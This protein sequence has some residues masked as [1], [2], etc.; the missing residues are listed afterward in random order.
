MNDLLGT[1][2][3]SNGTLVPSGKVRVEQVRFGG[4][5]AYNAGSVIPYIGLNYIYDLKKP[6]GGVMNGVTPANDRD[7]WQ[8]QLG[9][10]FRS[11][12]SLYGNV[13]YSTD[14]SRKE[15]KNDQIMFSLGM[16]F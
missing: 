15:V 7:A 1:Y 6:N 8:L 13:Q 11:T 12:G 10:Q 5:A 14:Q 4:Q 3:L 9:M 2:T 16:R